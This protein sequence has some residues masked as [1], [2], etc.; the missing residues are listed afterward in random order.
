MFSLI[1]LTHRFDKGDGKEKKY[2]YDLYLKN[3]KYI[4]NWDLVDLSAYKIIGKYLL[5]KERSVLYD[6]A[7]S[8]DLWEQRIAIISTFEFI[9]SKEFKDTLKNL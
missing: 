6:L 5:D 9:R 7:H 2:I 4:N 1:C 8:K 3:T